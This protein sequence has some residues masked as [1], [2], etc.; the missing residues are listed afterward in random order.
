MQ[1]TMGDR[2]FQLRTGRHIS[3]ETI[4][5][6]LGV[7]RQT[8]SKWETNACTPDTDKVCGLSRLFCVSTDFL[9]LG[10]TTSEVSAVSVQANQSSALPQVASDAGR[11]LAVSEGLSEHTAAFRSVELCRSLLRWKVLLALGSLLAVFSLIALL[12]L[13]ILPGSVI[14]RAEEVLVI[15]RNVWFLNLMKCVLS[16]LLVLSVSGMGVCINLIKRR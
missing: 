8:V 4:A 14:P 3:Q 1:E 2:I 5:H 15:Q 13:L 7:S 10:K 9:I 6:E 16:V 11:K 12:L